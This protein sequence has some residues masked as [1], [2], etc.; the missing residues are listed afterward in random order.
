MARPHA[1]GG[2][3]GLQVWRVAENMLNKQQQTA[4]MG[5]SSTLRVERGTN[6]FSL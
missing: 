2:G 1:A 6:N 5:W 4:D 3:S